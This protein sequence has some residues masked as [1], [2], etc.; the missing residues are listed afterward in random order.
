MV[1]KMTKQEILINITDCLDKE[2]LNAA[3][4]SMG[5]SESNYNPYFLTGKCFTTEELSVMSEIE[6]NN[7]IKLAEYASDTFY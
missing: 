1:N 6:L 4:N 7:I 2:K 5:V 3:R